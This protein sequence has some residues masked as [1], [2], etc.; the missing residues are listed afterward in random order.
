MG[1]ADLFEQPLEQAVG[2]KEADKGGFV[3]VPDPDDEKHSNGAGG[4]RSLGSMTYA[5]L[6]SFLYAVMTS[7][8]GIA[9][10]LS[11]AILKA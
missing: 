4:L 2:A 10:T 5:G 1:E 7:F 6:K 3:Y 9:P 11:Q 8:N